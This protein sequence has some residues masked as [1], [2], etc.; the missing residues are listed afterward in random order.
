MPISPYQND[1]IIYYLQ[2]IIFTTKV[3][4][5]IFLIVGLSLNLFS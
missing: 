1:T 3:E 2:T 4:Y 5:Y